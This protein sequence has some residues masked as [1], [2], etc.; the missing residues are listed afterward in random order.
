[1]PPTVEEFRAYY[2][3]MVGHRLENTPAAQTLLAEL[4]R[5]PR[6]PAVP[7]QLDPAWSALHGTLGRLAQLVT[8]GT[9]PPELRELLDQ[10]WTR[11]Q[12]AELDA[13][14]AAVRAGNAILPERLRYM[15]EVARVRSGELRPGAA[16]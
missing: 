3:H 5:P 9:L 14:A 7:A 11:R 10:R 6:P 1:M 4:K 12:Q 2:R 8:V 13:L 15:R 16:Q